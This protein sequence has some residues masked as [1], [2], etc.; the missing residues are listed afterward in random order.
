MGSVTAPHSYNRGNM[1]LKNNRTKMKGRLRAKLIKGYVKA[2]FVWKTKN[3][4]SLNYLRNVISYYV[5]QFFSRK[6][7]VLA[8][9]GRLS[10]KLKHNGQVID[11]GIV[12]HGLV[13][14]AFVNLLVDEMQAAAAEIDDF[15]YHDSGVGVTPAA[16]GDVDIETTDGVSRATG[17]QIEGA[18]AN[19]Y[20]SVG[21]ITYNSTK[22]ITEHGLFS[23]A[24]ST[25]LLDRHTFS[26][27]NVDD[28]DQIEFTYELT[29]SAG[30]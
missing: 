24:A 23:S 28:T 19:I 7:N 16:V 4:L 3:I 21:T 5:M 18:S 30:G 25:T 1:K 27:I 13:T 22:A 14:T 8:A 29:V 17:T 26:A 11:Y 6:T 10:A 20:K 12:A 9:T 15:K 2:P